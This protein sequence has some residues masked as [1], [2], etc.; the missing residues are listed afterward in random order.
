MTSF[1][2]IPLALTP[3]PVTVVFDVSFMVL[4]TLGASVVV[5][6]TG[7]MFL[8]VWCRMMN[9]PTPRFRRR[10]LAYG[11]GY[12]AALVMATLMMLLVKDSSR[13]PGWF[14]ASLFGQALAVHAV[15][16]PFVLKTPWGKATLAQAMALVLYGAVLV[17]AMAPVIIH[18][19]KA[20]DQAEWRA[21]LEQL[22][23]TVTAGKGMDVG[24]LPETLADIENTGQAIILLS[25]HERGEVVYLGDYVKQYY[26]SI[27]EGQFVSSMAKIKTGH[28]ETSPLIWQEPEPGSYRLHVCYYDGTVA[29][30]SR[31]VFD[32]H[33]RCTVVELGRNQ[34]EPT[35]RPDSDQP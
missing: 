22:Y 9:L 21:D 12:L 5:P 15:V 11:A 3:G 2:A 35:T 24:E 20:V 31:R 26:S 17:I 16:V 1:V 23:R 28:P 13:V 19:R 29:Y 34:P 27:L 10:W 30:L 4:A 7:A 8:G 25:D 6:M 33:L 14:L 32:S 18:V